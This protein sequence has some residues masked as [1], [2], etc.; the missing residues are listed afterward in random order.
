[1]KAHGELNMNERKQTTDTDDETKEASTVDA[2]DAGDNRN[3]ETVV[4]TDEI[5]ATCPENPWNWTT[6]KKWLTMSAVGLYGFLAFVQS[7][8]EYLVPLT[9]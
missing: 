9:Y 4:M 1:M 8:V 7:V 2:G 6:W 3:Y 5:W